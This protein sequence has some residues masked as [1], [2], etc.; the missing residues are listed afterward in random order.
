MLFPVSGSQLGS[1]TSGLIQAG[2]YSAAFGYVAA[3]PLQHYGPALV[4]AIA[5]RAS[6]TGG[7]TPGQRMA[8]MWYLRFVERTTPS[9]Y[10]DSGTRLA[11]EHKGLGTTA[12]T[13]SLRLN[14]SLI[15]GQLALYVF[16]GDGA[17]NGWSEVSMS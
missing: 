5:V 17:N 6:A 3:T 1:Y 10:P 13:G 11:V 2:V 8:T 14:T 15:T 16:T 7:I 9:Y 12:E 4:R